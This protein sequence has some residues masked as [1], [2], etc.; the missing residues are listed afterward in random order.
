M[1]TNDR[2]FFGHPVGLR[3]LFLTE[4]WERFSY[5]GMRALLILF[6]TAPLAR[7]GLG[8]AT[9]EAG[10]IYGLYTGM[11][12]LLALP[13]G[14]IADKIL[15]ARRAVLVGGIIIAIGHFCLALPSTTTFFIGLVFIVTGT[16]LLKP[17]VSTMVGQ[18]YAP[19]DARR[20]AAFSIFYMGINLGAFIAPLVCSY[21]GENIN[22]HYGFGLAGIGMT[23]GVIQFAAGAKT[24]GSAGIAPLPTRKDQF[25]FRGSIVLF[26]LIVAVGGILAANGTL[27]IQALSSG[28]GFLL[29]AIVIVLFAG[30]LIFGKWT[31][32]ERSRLIAI[33]VL[34]AAAA[35]FWSIYEQAGSTLN[36]FAERNTDRS[37]PGMA[38]PFPAGWFQSLPALFVIAIAPMFA[39]L[40]VKLGERNPS[41]TIKFSVGLL[42]GGVSFMILIPIAGKMGVSPI[43]LTLTYLLQTIGELCISPVGMSTMTK[44]APKR[45]ASLMM[46]VWFVS[47]SVGDYLSG[48]LASVYDT[49]PLPQL[50][51]TVGASAIVLGAILA[52]FYK[53]MKQLIGSEE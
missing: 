31:R 21:V 43:W 13:G 49:M 22:W 27:S 25:R 32:E 18:L 29:T 50:F 10:A 45:I 36:L 39:W 48:K 20:D 11:V 16:G 9:P 35:L 37:V 33:F 5:Y 14:W 3:T 28:F 44:L 51:G 38:Q 7:N 1:M 34:F 40:W 4:L 26:L 52:L 6:M 47:I 23:A 12:Y 42:F 2:G 19:H 53:P 46:G 30:M 41:S 17:N 24:L 8:M 15:G